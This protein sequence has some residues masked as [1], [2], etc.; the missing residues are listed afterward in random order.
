MVRGYFNYHAVSGNIDRL[1]STTVYWLSS[2]ASDQERTW[3]VI[4]VIKPIAEAHRCSIARMSLAWLL[5]QLIMTSVILGAKRLDQLTDNLRSIDVRLA[6]DELK[7]IDEASKL[8]R[9]YPGWMLE[10]QDFCRL[11]PP[12][13][14]VWD[15]MQ[16]S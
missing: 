12:A 6:P 14:A 8:P 7:N 10:V 15:N 4:D 16:Q 3:N 2:A 11:E 5:A 9:E 13:Q 1:Q